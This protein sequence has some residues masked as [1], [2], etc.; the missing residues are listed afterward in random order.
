MYMQ[1]FTAD[2]IDPIAYV[3]K[4]K[5]SKTTDEAK[6]VPAPT[7]T[8]EAPPARL[9]SPQSGPRPNA[10]PAL[11]S[12]E[13]VMEAMEAELAKSRLS[14]QNQKKAS[15]AVGPKVAPPSDVKKEKGKTKGKE[16]A[17]SFASSDD[18]DE[19]DEAAMEAELRAV[20][21]REEGDSGDEEPMDYA[22]IR[23][24]LE[25]FKSQAGLAGPVGTLMGRLEP[26]WRLPRDES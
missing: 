11:D 17:V 22:M 16:K 20:L 26:N 8:V 25:S 18:E 13:A 2:N 7:S 1:E 19:D 10:N 9:R 5:T 12:F 15:S 3:P 23:N 4:T 21:E 14:K 6:I 24:F